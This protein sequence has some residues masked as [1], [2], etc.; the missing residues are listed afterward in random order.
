MGVKPRVHPL[1]PGEEFPG[2]LLLGKKSF[3]AGEGRLAETVEVLLVILI[4][5]RSRVSE[6]E[7]VLK[8]FR[9]CS[10]RC[11]HGDTGW[12][13]LGAGSAERENPRFQISQ[14]C[15]SGPS[16]GQVLPN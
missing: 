10:G 9:R 6:Q 2:P 16:W 15:S 14:R 12:W 4:I 7:K 3:E 1:M 8:Q 13:S 11:W 5:S